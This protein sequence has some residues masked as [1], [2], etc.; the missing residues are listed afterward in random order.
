MTKNVNVLYFSIGILIAGL[1]QMTVD[2]GIGLTIYFLAYMLT[3]IAFVC[4][5]VWI[6][7]GIIKYRVDIESNGHDK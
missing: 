6:M 1:H 2:G 4:F 3:P 5:I 7:L